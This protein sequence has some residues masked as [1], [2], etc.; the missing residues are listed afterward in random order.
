M[1]SRP[2]QSNKGVLL[3]AAALLFL[4]PVVCY[5]QTGPA[6]RTG[7]AITTGPCSPAITGN[8]NVLTFNCSSSVALNK[9]ANVG[10]K[11]TIVLSRTDSPSGGK[12]TIVGSGFWVNDSGYAL[13]CLNSIA[14]VPRSDLRAGVP[15]QPLLG[16]MITIGGGVIYTHAQIITEDHEDNLALVRVYNSPF[17]RKLHMFVWAKNTKTGKAE[18]QSE[19]Y[20]VAEFSSRLPDMGDEVVLVTRLAK[21]EQG[22]IP[23]LEAEF[24]YVTRVGLEESQKMLPRIYISNQFS[25]NYRGA[26]L[27]SASGDVI[28]VVVGPDQEHHT[29]VVPTK[30]LHRL[31]TDAKIRTK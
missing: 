1:E 4:A 6:G 3:A 18:G 24:G 28:G 12:P 30:S 29:M 8:N 11:M 13:T 25:E 20:A 22:V 17:E 14:G 23:V 27:L 19:Q 15:F 31:L 2:P 26:A 5:A 10:A 21:P 7:E 9:V 16:N